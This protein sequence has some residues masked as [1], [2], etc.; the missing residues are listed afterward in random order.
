M[1]TT[2]TLPPPQ[3]AVWQ[4]LISGITGCNSLLYQVLTKY[5]VE[6]HISLAM[7]QLLQNGL[8]SFYLNINSFYHFTSIGKSALG[9]LEHF[10]EI[11][12]TN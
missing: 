11:Y 6:W 3:S 12:I 8:L 4:S 5:P 2:F 10:T 1:K 9:H 7:F